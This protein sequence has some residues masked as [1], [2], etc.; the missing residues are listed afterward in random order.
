MSLTRLTH[1]ARVL[2]IR[3][4]LDARQGLTIAELRQ[5]FGVSR[6]TVYNDLKALGDAGVPIYSEPAPS[7][8]VLWKL[9]PAA[10]RTT[11]TLTIGQI[12]SLSLARLVLTFLEG[13][14]LHGE[15]STVMSRLGQG[16]SPR[17]RGYVDQMSRKMAVAHF[18]FK[19]YAGKVDVLN[20]LLTGLLYDELVEVWYRPPGKAVRRHVV[21]PYTLL[22]HA[23]ALYLICHSRTRDERRVL[24]VDRITRSRWLKGQPFDYPTDYRPESLTD[25]AL[26]VIRGEPTD[27][28]LLFDAAQAPYLTERTWHP[29]QS[30]RR[31]KDGRLRMR[32]RVSATVELLQWLLGYSHSAEIVAPPE[33]RRHARRI[34]ERAA[35]RHA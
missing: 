30:F 9:H 18:G 10:R 5:T 8:E 3:E 27:V 1:A 13:T 6:R 20:D 16:L 2:R 17:Y 31:L 35:S 25:G 21:E 34:L 23:E 4:M 19:S 24:A 32:L 26:G 7:G 28:E 11:L 33:L 14:D 12:L 22:V 15:L 29:S